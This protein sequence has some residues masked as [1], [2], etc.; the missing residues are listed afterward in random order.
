MSDTAAPDPAGTSTPPAA[1]TD[2]PVPTAS[3]APAA[4]PGT[5]A[6]VD[7]EAKYRETLAHSRKH[8]QRAK[9]G[10][11][12]IKELADLKK[13][14][15]TD[16]DKRATELQEAVDRA[17]AAEQRAV[18]AEAK[19]LGLTDDDL[20]L[21]D[22]VPADQYLD[23]AQ[24]LAGRLKAAATPASSGPEVGGGH[25]AGVELD[26]AKLAANAASRKPKVRIF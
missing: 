15:M 16:D 25:T 10:A 9:E 20:A 1:G 4:Q 7:Y 11:A 24:A 8:E 2:A 6:P 3:P 26:P 18:K 17:A 13:A 5:E 19:A 22:G 21:L 23:R 12:A 14:S